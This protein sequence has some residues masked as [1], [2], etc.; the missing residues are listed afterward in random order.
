ML[1]S[2]MNGEKGI[3]TA[4]ENM[5]QQQKF[6]F[7]TE[8]VKERPI[9]K[10]KLIRK[11]VITISMALIFG[12]IACL[13]FA[14]LE[15]V[16]SNW[17]YP[18][19]KIEK[20]EIPLVTEEILPEDMKVHEEVTL[21]PTQEVIDT[22]KNEIQL[23]TKD[24]Q[25]LYQS[26]HSLVLSMKSA[27]VTITAVSQEVDLFRR[28]YESTGKTTGYIFAQ[29]NNEIL[30]MVTKNDVLE[31]ENIEVSFVDGSMAKASLRDIDGNTG[32]A[33]VAVEKDRISDGTLEVIRFINLGSSSLST[34][35]AS[36]VIALGNPLGHPSV[37]YGM[38]TSMDQVISMW[39]CN[40]KLLTTDIY[41][42][43]DATGILMDM[44]GKVVGIINQN[45][46]PEGASNLI[47]A[48]GISEIKAA[49]QRMSNGMEN[50]YVGI[51]GADIPIEVFREKEIPTGVYVT[52]IDMDSPS[53]QAG[54]QSGDIIVQIEKNTITSFAD[55]SKVLNTWAP[56]DT[57]EIYLMRQGQDGYK[58]AK[59]EVIVGT[60]N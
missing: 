34:L 42:S 48:L 29:N 44:N 36:P 8:K 50:V 25:K 43:K 53:M 57:K 14:F 59:V 28:E 46:N 52:G 17:L 38:I 3:F 23:S 54:I 11:T 15:P 13:T 32:L 60:K 47:S 56:G 1:V 18:E 26:I 51:K 10:K 39:D 24:Y 16:I 37:V 27:E 22:L 30:I 4:G 33:V 21:E 9:N 41:G 19:E 2:L 55:Y 58:K 35:I 45:Y 31:Q 6:E 5:D 20:I 12:L 40:Y 7:I 49:L